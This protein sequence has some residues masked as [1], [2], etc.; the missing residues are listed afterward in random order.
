[1][2]S[3]LFARAFARTRGPRNHRYRFPK[4]AGAGTVL[5]TDRRANLRL[6]VFSSNLSVSQPPKAS[7]ITP[8]ISGIEANKPV[9]ITVKW[10]YS[11]RYE[12]SHER[13]NH[14]E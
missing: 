7:P 13:K 12:G 11:T 8:A 14:R 4:T 2:W 9:L 1:M 5:T 6:F 3:T 10:R